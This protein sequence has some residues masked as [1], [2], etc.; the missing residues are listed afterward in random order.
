MGLFRVL[1]VITLLLPSISAPSQMLLDN[2]AATP[3]HCCGAHMLDNGSEAPAALT[4]EAFLVIS[5]PPGLNHRP[6]QCCQ[7]CQPQQ[8]LL[9]PNATAT[10]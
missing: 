10:N 5:I 8:Q 4:P 9:D 6:P 3:G 2:L 1:P 7:F